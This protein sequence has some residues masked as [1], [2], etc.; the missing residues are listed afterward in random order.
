MQAHERQR[1][2]TSAANE[3]R[4]THAPDGTDLTLIRM[5]LEK[6]PRERLQALQDAANSVL[7]LSRGKRIS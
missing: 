1:A 7:R 5:M 2:N 4:P 6:T 3:P